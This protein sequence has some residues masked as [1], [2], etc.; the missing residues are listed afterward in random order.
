MITKKALNKELYKRE[1][2]LTNSAREAWSKIIQE[3]KIFNPKGKVLLPSYIGWS[4]NEGS[5]IFD[6]VS[7]SGLDYDFYD[8]GVKLEINFEDLKIKINENDE[9]LVLLVHYFGFIDVKYDEITSWLTDNNVFFVEDAAHAWLTDLIGGKSGRKGNFSFYSLHK[10]L[11]LSKGGMMVSNMPKNN[12]EISK[13]NP[14]VELNYDLLS[15]FNIR[16]ANYKYL[17]SLLKDLSGIEIVY[18][19]LEDGI[20]PQTLPI[21]IKNYNRDN[22]YEEMNEAGFGVVSL[23]HTMINDLES[24]KSLASSVASKKIMN[25]PIHQ[26]VSKVELKK[27]A[28]KLKNIL[29]V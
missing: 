3:Y 12:K 27:M 4:S 14:F 5:G 11:P 15:I 18:E 21:I 24:N 19:K 23:Y 7:N 13:I 16:R 22:L 17:C 1:W 25:L 26:D 6:S 10:L 8:L 28:L 2:I 29:N 9:P 20:C